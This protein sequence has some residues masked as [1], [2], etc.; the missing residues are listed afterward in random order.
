M[1]EWGGRTFGNS[2]TPTQAHDDLKRP[3][4]SRG[5][6][7]L[8]CTH[9]TTRSACKGKWETQGR[10]Q[11]TAVLPWLERKKGYS[12]AFDERKASHYEHYRHIFEAARLA[13]EGKV[14]SEPHKEEDD[15][16]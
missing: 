11:Y 13:A 6:R 2:T 1:N 3:R 8:R 10:H 14:P 16:Y 9:R 5:P 4:R 7:L 12:L 15:D